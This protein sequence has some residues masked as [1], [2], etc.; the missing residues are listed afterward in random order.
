MS[1]VETQGS[2]NKKFLGLPLLRN[3][4]FYYYLQISWHNFGIAINQIDVLN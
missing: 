4:L 1:R 3:D 2:E